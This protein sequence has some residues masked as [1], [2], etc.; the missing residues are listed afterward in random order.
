MNGSGKVGLGATDM[1]S[2]QV[3][4]HD[5]TVAVGVQE[6][7]Q[8]GPQRP[9]LYYSAFLVTKGQAHLRNVLRKQLASAGF[10][11][12]SAPASWEQF[13]FNADCLLLL[14]CVPQSDGRTY[15][16]V[17]ATSSADGPAKYWSDEM[18]H[19]IQNDTSVSFD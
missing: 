1:L 8:P 2:S 4:R 18:T 16:H 14:T 13:G 17:V 10:E 9:H 19:R 6:T 15:V 3:L 12:S 11:S 7:V 5:L